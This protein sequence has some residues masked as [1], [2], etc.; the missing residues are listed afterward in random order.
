M[1]TYFARNL[2]E[3]RDWLTEHHDSEREVW[4][5]FHKV[6][7]GVACIEYGDALDEALC[8]GWI[9]S[10]VK[11]LDDRRFARKFTPRKP[12]SRW[13]DVNRKRYAALEA[14]G[15]L[16][17]PGRAR[18][19]TGR[20]SAAGPARLELPAKLPAYIQSA[21][22]RQPKALR[23]YETLPPSERRRCFAWIESAKRDDTKTRRL[24][25]VIRLL[26]AGKPLGLK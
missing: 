23:Y 2:E 20:G 12:N 11:R 13:S 15:R 14:N 3:W 22:E 8:F 7:T 19:P 6:H 4:L 26:S 5:I 18:A 1:K 16:K 10:L 21:L 24:K 17:P 9:D 25:E